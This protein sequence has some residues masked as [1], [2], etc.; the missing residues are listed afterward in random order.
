MLLPEVGNTWSF[1]AAIGISKNSP[2]AKEAWE[3]IK[4]YVSPETQA[5][6]YAAVG[7]YP[8]RTSVA[9]SLGKDGKIEGADA[10]VEQ[11][12]HVNELPRSALW[13]GPFTQ[14][15]TEAIL[16]AAQK[17]TDADQVIDSLA[18]QWNDLKAE[19]K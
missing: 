9:E 10:I 14:K 19:Y 17:G 8:S 11:S 12:K 18:K 1:P 3:F 4:W 6:I 2:N 7:L 15:V 16:Q 13:W 5:A